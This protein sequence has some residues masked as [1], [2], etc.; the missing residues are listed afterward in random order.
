MHYQAGESDRLRERIETMKSP[1]DVAWL[2]EEILD[3]DAS[4]DVS[5]EETHN[6]L[7][8]LFSKNGR[9]RTRRSA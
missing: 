5:L 9:N 4:G 8:L 2:E 1:D 7:I 6:L 3:S